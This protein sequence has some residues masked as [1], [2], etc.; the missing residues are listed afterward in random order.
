MQQEVL[1]LTHIERI[2]NQ[3]VTADIS[4]SLCAREALCILTEDID[5]KNFLLDFLQ[6][7]ISPVHGRLY[8]NDT[9]CSLSGVKGARQAGIWVVN[10]VQLVE[11]MSVADNLFLI[12]SSFRRHGGFIST[13]AMHAAA[14]ELLSRFSMEYIQPSSPV[15]A[16][17]SFDTFLVSILCAYTQ[18]AKILVLNTPSIICEK[19]AE[20]KK[21][22]HLVNI[23]RQLGLA[24]LWLSS[25]WTPLFQNFNR[26]AVIKGGVVTELSRLTV[27]PPPVSADKFSPLAF[28]GLNDKPRFSEKV[29]SV[30]YP[31]DQGASAVCFDLYKGEILGIHDEEHLLFHLFSS[32]DKFLPERTAVF[33]PQ[34]GQDRIFPLMHLYDNITLLLNT[35]LYNSIGFLN[36]RIRNYLALS[37][38]RSIHAEYLAD[39]YGAAGS[40]GNVPM[41]DQF[42]I[43]IAKWLCIHPKIFVFFDPHTVYD[44]LTETLFAELLSD[45]QDQGISILMISRNE[46]SLSKFCTRLITI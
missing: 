35:P 3:Q 9:A 26:Y 15:H 25:K 44:H 34:A 39:K 37:T 36:R 2:I 29:L 7:K 40:L 10:E 18:G 1:R 4:L 8:I 24:F 45:L 31:A 12:S 22:Q 21:L 28:C 41:K 14:K 42:L 20:V 13:R 30:S 46:E 6:G 32:P 5:T 27:I 16:L 17:S 38:L 33:Y 11:S 19:P 23:L 43:E